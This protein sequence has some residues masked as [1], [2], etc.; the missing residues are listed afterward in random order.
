[1]T[2]CINAHSATYAPAHAATRAPALLSCCYTRAGPLQ[3]QK[4]EPA[5]LNRNCAAPVLSL[6]C[7]L[8]SYWALHAHTGR[9]TRVCTGGSRLGQNHGRNRLQSQQPE[10]GLVPVVLSGAA[11]GPPAG[12]RRAT[13]PLL[14]YRRALIVRAHFC[15][16][17]GHN[18]PPLRV[19]RRCTPLLRGAAPEHLPRPCKRLGARLNSESRCH[20][21]LFQAG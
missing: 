7:S 1:M 18:R 21:W 16:A 12:G 9:A 14:H 8:F 2:L 3:K 4:K 6:Q 17:S 5:D 19:F 15:T 20:A 11:R 13:G 10:K